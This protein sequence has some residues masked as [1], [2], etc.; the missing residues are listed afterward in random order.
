MSSQT[1]QDYLL[2]SEYAGIGTSLYLN[3][4]EAVSPEFD[5][6]KIGSDFA[7]KKKMIRDDFKT[8][9]D[10]VHPTLCNHLIGSSNSERR[11]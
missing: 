9:L 4:S 1:H 7:H 8:A 2:L 6:L 3:N 5:M 11:T 10:Q